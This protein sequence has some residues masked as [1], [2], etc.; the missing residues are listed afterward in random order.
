MRDR[1]VKE[2]L[3]DEAMKKNIC[4]EQIQD[5]VQMKRE[6]MYWYQVQGQLLVTGAKFCDF[7]LFTRQD[8]FKER[9]EP[10]Q[11]TM[12]Q[13]LTKMVNVFDGFVCEK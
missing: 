13:I 11:Y 6:H 3:A 4:I 12:E 5:K 10:D 2:A 8:L 7:V 1:T 9:I